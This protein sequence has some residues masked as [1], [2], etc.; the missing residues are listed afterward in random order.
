MQ[1]STRIATILATATVVAVVG[2]GWAST[3]GAPA[4]APATSA[5]SAPPASAGVVRVA[6]S[7][8]PG[9]LPVPTGTSKPGA[10]HAFVAGPLRGWEV[11]IDLAAVPADAA[12]DLLRDD[13]TAQGF[14]LRSGSRDVFAARQRARR[15]EI[16]VARVETHGRGDR[17]RE[18]LTLGVGSRPA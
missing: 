11:A 3:V 2:A 6:T 14:T 15:W 4:Y 17:A 13:L 8:I 9:G 10:P 18:I 1:T 7:V 12:L 5:S 16:V